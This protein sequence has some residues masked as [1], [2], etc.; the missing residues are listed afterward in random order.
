MSTAWIDGSASIAARSVNAVI[1]EPCFALSSAE[2]SGREDQTA[3]TC[4]CDVELIAA[5]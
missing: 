5:M 2:S 3:V 1:G 4:A